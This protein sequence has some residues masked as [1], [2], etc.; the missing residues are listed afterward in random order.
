MIWFDISV[1]VTRFDE[2]QRAWLRGQNL[3]FMV[4][5]EEV[6]GRKTITVN[7]RSSQGEPDKR[8]REKFPEIHETR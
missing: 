7:L 8:F 2:E 3:A 1:E 4:T 6:D 5:E